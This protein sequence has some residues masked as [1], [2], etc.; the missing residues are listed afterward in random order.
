M[1]SKNIGSRKT[2]DAIAKE[3]FGLVV[4]SSFGPSIRKRLA[5][6][7]SDNPVVSESWSNEIP[8]CIFNLKHQW[9]DVPAARTTALIVANEQKNTIVVAI[10]RRGCNRSTASPRQLSDSPLK[11]GSNVIVREALNKLNAGA[12]MARNHPVS[13]GSSSPTLH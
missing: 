4:G 3:L 7:V 9:T 8:I 2:C 5:A 11:S 12:A 13:A 10:N 6:S 1:S